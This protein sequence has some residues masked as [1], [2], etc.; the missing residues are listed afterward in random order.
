[1]SLIEREITF[2][3]FNLIRG[4]LLVLCENLNPFDKLIDSNKQLIRDIDAFEE[5]ITCLILV[6]N[7]VLTRIRED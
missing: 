1:M 4:Y 2:E 5:L 6:L 3:L 7:N